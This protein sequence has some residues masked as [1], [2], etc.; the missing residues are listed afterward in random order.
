VDDPFCSEDLNGW[1]IL[2]TAI[3]NLEEAEQVGIT[4]AR[5]TGNIKINPTINSHRE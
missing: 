3:A 4:A 1:K 5:E 2:G